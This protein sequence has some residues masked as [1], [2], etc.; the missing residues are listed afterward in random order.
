MASLAGWLWCTLGLPQKEG[1]RRGEA[2]QSPKRQL[3]AEPASILPSRR[4]D[5]P[6][7]VDNANPQELGEFRLSYLD[8][9]HRGP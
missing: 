7:S 8:A 5:L 4:P 6:S 1:P 9:V 2:A 3:P